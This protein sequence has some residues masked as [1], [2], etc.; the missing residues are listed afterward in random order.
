M[1]KETTRQ[2]ARSP[3]ETLWIHLLLHV[4]FS[5]S[6]LSQAPIRNNSSVFGRRSINR[7]ADLIKETRLAFQESG[8]PNRPSNLEPGKSVNSLRSLT[9]YSILAGVMYYLYG[10]RVYDEL[11]ISE[12]VSAY[13]LYTNIRSIGNKDKQISP[14]TAYYMARELVEHKVLIPY[15]PDCNIRYDSAS[16]QHIKNACPFCRKVGKGDFDDIEW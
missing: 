6:L 14:D 8:W 5:K 7:A 10:E 16:E 13:E 15:C 11:T 2:S 12:I 1:P 4:G 9:E 3:Q